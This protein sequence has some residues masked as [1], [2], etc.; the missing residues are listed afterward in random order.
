MTLQILEGDELHGRA[1]IWSFL[2]SVA[3]SGLWS[4]LEDW[5]GLVIC[6][7]RPVAHFWEFPGS[8]QKNV[9]GKLAPEI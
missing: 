3:L 8:N 4:G 9:T 7:L 5:S 2:W 1:A 6:G